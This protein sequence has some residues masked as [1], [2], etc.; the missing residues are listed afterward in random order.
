M[1]KLILVGP[2][3]TGTTSIFR[4]LAQHPHLSPSYVKELNYFFGSGS[5]NSP[6]SYLEDS[7]M[8]KP[9][10]RVALE[11]SP[12]YFGF[13]GCMARNVVRV[14]PD[15]LI[16]IVMREPMD[17]LR[18]LLEHV[19]V[20][21][22]A[23][24]KLDLNQMVL[25]GM[26]AAIDSAVDPAVD[27]ANRYV[28]REGEYVDLL[29]Q[30]RQFFPD[31]RI[32]VVFY[33]HMFS[34]KEASSEV[35]S[36]LYD[37]LGIVDEDLPVLHENMGREVKFSRLHKA[38]LRLNDALEPLLNRYPFLRNLLRAVY[39]AFNERREKEMAHIST[40]TA[41]EVEEHYRARNSGLR[42]QVAGV[43]IGRVPDWVR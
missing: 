1:K 11:A 10:E 25:S 41:R 20:K 31:D 5:A 32:R 22:N 21:R 42:A 43:V 12:L 39:Y 17:R 27:D 13:G 30:W 19:A 33:E 40:D 2:T 6:A 23:G 36:Q 9:E 14:L 3:R 35:L 4:M 16:L 37:W 38:A 29:H 26:R 18:S 15:A 7:F 24:E 8:R 34:S 28:V